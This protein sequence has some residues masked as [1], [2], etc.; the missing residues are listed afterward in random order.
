MNVWYSKEICCGY[1]PR[2]RDQLCSLFQILGTCCWSVTGERLIDFKY[3]N[4]DGFSRVL[5][6]Y[7]LIYLS[8]YVRRHKD[9]MHNDLEHELGHA[10]GMMHS[11]NK[12]CVMYYCDNGNN[13]HQYITKQDV[14]VAKYLH[15]CLLNG[16]Y[17]H[18]KT[19]PVIY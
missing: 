19:K 7:S 8:N 14:K 17:Y 18:E 10:F 9:Y 3:D 13:K 11:K 2:D 16:N 1:I 15:K 4:S 12:R 5:R 6:N